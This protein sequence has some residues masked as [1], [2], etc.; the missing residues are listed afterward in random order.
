MFVPGTDWETRHSVVGQQ[1]RLARLISHI[2]HTNEFRQYC[3]VGNTAQHCRLGL[4]QDTNFA[5]DLEDSKFTSEGVL[6]VFGSPTFVPF[7]CMCK[8][9]TSVSH[10]STEYV[11][12]G[13]RMDGLPALDVWDIVIEVLRSTNNI[14]RH[15]KLA[16]GDLCGTGRTFHE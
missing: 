6:C 10:S 7:S 9:Q 3:H 11:D 2:H 16:Q 8:K 5:G 13:L 12:A 15:A 14:A 1:R 4:F